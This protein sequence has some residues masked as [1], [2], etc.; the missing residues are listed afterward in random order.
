MT[1]DKMD[2]PKMLEGLNKAL[3]QQFRSAQDFTLMAGS[4][5]GF[6]YQALGDK[7]WGFA[8]E[9]LAD[10][11]RLVE[12]I[13]ALGGSPTTQPATGTTASTIPTRRGTTAGSVSSRQT[14]TAAAPSGPT[15][16]TA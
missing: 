5:R 12:K 2:V 9:E 3:A 7:L 4:V 16:P 11:R 10:A 15:R 6:S 1:D 13:T 8:E 14:R